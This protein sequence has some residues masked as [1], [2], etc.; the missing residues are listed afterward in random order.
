MP[1]VTA[2]GELPILRAA[3]ANPP[4]L[5]TATNISRVSSRSIDYSTF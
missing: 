5:A 3:A 1:R 2:G 4:S